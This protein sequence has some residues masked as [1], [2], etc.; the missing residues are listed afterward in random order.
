MPIHN[1]PAVDG[2]KIDKKTVT[3]FIEGMRP[4]EGNAQEGLSE[5]APAALLY[6]SVRH[7]NS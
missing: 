7:A 1:V 5:Q 2:L 3:L 6:I 4:I